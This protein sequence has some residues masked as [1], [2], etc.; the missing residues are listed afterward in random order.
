MLAEKGIAQGEQLGKTM[1][2]MNR[3]QPLKSETI[4]FGFNRWTL[5]NEA[6]AQLDELGRSVQGLNRYVIELQGFTDKSG[7]SNI[8]DELS[9]KRAETVARYLT[10]NY[11]IPL[12][13]I[14]FIG[15]G[16]SQPVGD[17]KTREGRKM[18]RRVEVRVFVPETEKTSSVASSSEF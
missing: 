16:W 15:S 5:T 9:Q 3:F 13:S 12:R 7:A 1:E 18:N 10:S 14:H 4:L 17:D 6:K 11:K 8:N 2:A